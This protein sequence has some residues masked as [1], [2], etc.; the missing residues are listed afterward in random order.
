METG[1]VTGASAQPGGRRGQ[2]RDSLLGHPKLGV[3]F[4]LM[5][6]Q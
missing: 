2:D 3:V 5:M 6:S 1:A 4:S